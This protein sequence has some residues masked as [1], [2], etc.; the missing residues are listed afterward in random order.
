VGRGDVQQRVYP[1]DWRLGLR[2]SPFVLGGSRTKAWSR[3]ATASALCTPCPEMIRV[4]RNTGKFWVAL[5]QSPSAHVTDSLGVVPAFINGQNVDGGAF[6]I[7]LDGP[8]AA[9][10]LQLV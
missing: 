9:S 7:N 4:L 2:P 6:V 1:R 3:R 10:R 8:S 5:T